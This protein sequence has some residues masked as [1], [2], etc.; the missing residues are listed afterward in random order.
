[1]YTV[2]ALVKVVFAIMDTGTA[3]CWRVAC[4]SHFSTYCDSH[5]AR[6]GSEQQ[7]NRYSHQG[8]RVAIVVYVCGYACCFATYILAKSCMYAVPTAVA[9]DAVQSTF[10]RGDKIFP[11]DNNFISA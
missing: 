2:T 5:D 4:V 1:M 6:I 3:P 8:K 7:T 10:V 9:K 11:V